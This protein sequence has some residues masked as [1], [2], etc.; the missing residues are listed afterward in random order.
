MKKI[1]FTLIE[2]LVTLL[3]LII[4]ISV[5]V[6]IISGRTTEARYAQAKADIA[7]LE[8]AITAYEVDLGAYPPMGIENL[9]KALVHSMSGNAYKP[10]DKRWKGPYIDLKE[11]RLDSEGRILDPWGNPYSYVPYYNYP[12]AGTKRADAG[13]LEETYYNP[14][15]FQIYSKGKNGITNPHPYAGTESDDINNWYGDERT[16]H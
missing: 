15:T 2:L 1:G 4:L 9:K 6:P 14:Y 16:R 5:L 8:T 3:I 11:E 13:P 10:N 12:E 7:A